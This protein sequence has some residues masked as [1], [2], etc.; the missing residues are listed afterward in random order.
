MSASKKCIT[1]AGMGPFG[2]DV[3][4]KDGLKSN[5]APCLAKKQREYAKAHPETWAN[6]AR[7]N[8][9]KLKA[10][11]AARY[12]ANPEG[13]KARVLAYRAKNPEKATLWQTIAN[14]RK[15]GITPKQKEQMLAKQAGKCAICADILKSG[16]TGMQIDHDHATGRMRGLLCH[17]CN[18]LL[19]HFKEDLPTFVRAIEYI[20]YYSS[21]SPIRK[22][23]RQLEF[24]SEE[25]ARNSRNSRKNP[26]YEQA[27]NLWYSFRLTPA[28]FNRIWEAQLGLCGICLSPLEAGLRTHID[29]DERLGAIEG[30][31]GILCRTCNLGLGQARDKPE[32]LEAAIVYLKIFR[33]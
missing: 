6:W 1:C 32:I 23:R 3:T 31:R 4:A 5:C 28:D 25:R 12:A 27:Y 21:M 20:R 16:R 7:A 15:Y 26:L 19:G 14:L 11:D 22:Y 8:A 9:E 10:K 13:E 24:G 2:P 18:R 33:K 17:R 29:H 30:L